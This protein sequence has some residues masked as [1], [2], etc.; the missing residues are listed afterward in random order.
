[1]ASF[2]ATSP[3]HKP[4]LSSPMPSMSSPLHPGVFLAGLWLPAELWGASAVESQCWE[5]PELWDP[6]AAL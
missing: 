2:M 4:P 1:M 6:S 3:K 5:V